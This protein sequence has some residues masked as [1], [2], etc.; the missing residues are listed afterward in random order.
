MRCSCGSMD[1][2]PGQLAA[3]R[4]DHC[5]TAAPVPSAYQ[6]EVAL[7]ITGLHQV[8]QH[9]LRQYGVSRSVSRLP[10]TIP[11]WCAGVSSTA[12]APLPRSSLNWRGCRP[13]CPQLLTGTQRARILHC[14]ATN[15]AGTEDPSEQGERLRNPGDDDHLGRINL[16]S[17]DSGP[18]SEPPLPGRRVTRADRRMPGRR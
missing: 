14:R 12:C 18:T 10:A 15:A 3:Q 13:P 17:A 2:R 11:F 9:Q 6:P 5:V 4:A 1:L 7:E 8:C 16:D